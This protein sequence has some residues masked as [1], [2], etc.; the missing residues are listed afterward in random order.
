MKYFRLLSM[1]PAL[2]D[3]P[4]A[5]PV[6]LEQLIALL[7]EDLAEGDKPLA[8]ALLG[9]LDC[10]NLEARLQGYEVFDQRAVLTAEAFDERTELPEYMQDFLEAHDSGASSEEYVFDGL[11]KRFYTSLV[12]V[13]EQ[14]GSNFLKDW[15]SYEITLRDTLAKSRAESLGDK[16]ELR[17]AGVAVETAESHAPLLAAMAEAANPM[18]AERLLDTAR[19]GKIDSISGIDPFS[20]DA[21][22]SYLA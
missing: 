13:G 20:T 7:F 1:L 4:G 14:S 17:A 6:P 15:A 22:L 21:A 5:P 8:L 12:E 2:P 16:P 3:A 10:Q 9:H 18:E 11:W 19:L